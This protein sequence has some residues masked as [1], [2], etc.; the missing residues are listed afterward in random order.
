MAGGSTG[1]MDNIIMQSVV[2]CQLVTQRLIQRP[3]QRVLD[4]VLFVV[5]F[6]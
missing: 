6:F 3:T 4:F 2:Q 1:L 5:A